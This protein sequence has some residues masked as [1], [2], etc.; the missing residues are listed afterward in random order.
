MSHYHVERKRAACDVYRFVMSLR[1]QKG[2]SAND[3]VKIASAAAGGASQRQIYEWLR[4]DLSPTTVAEKPDN[5]GATRL[6]N[7]DQESL[8]VGFAI[9]NRSFLEPVTLQ[10]LQQFCRSHLS[11]TPSLS[12]LSRT[13][14][15]YGFSSQ[16]S[17]SRSSRM[18]SEEVVDA[19][20]STIEEIRSYDFAPDQLLFMDE[21]GLWSNVR[22]PRTYHYQNWCENSSLLLLSRFFFTPHFHSSY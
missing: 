11:V 1:T 9:S 22:Q 3:V 15:E 19:A 17:M 12:T 6:L 13:M 8:L 21:T 7:D 20:I 10:T 5:R 4:Q 2:L 14:N 16:K 18:V